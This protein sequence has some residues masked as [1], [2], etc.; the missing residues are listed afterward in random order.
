MKAFKFLKNKGSIVLAAFMLCSSIGTMFAHDTITMYD[1]KTGDT[2]SEDVVS[3]DGTLGN[4][5][6]VTGYRNKRIANGYA[7]EVEWG[8]MVF[9]Y[10]DGTYDPYTGEMVESSVIV[11]QPLR[12]EYGEPTGEVTMREFLY[13]EYYG[14]CYDPNRLDE[15]KIGYWYGS[16]RRNA[17][18]IIRNLSEEVVYTKI[19]PSKDYSNSS[20]DEINLHVYSRDSVDINSDKFTKMN[21]PEGSME[22]W[23]NFSFLAGEPNETRIIAS[24]EYLECYLKGMEYD[25]YGGSD[26]Y[27]AHARVNVFGTPGD[28]FKNVSDYMQDG[29][30]GEKI[31]EITIS[32]SK[33]IIK[34]GSYIKGD[35]LTPI[36]GDT[37]LTDS[38]DGSGYDYY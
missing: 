15:R 18:I 11:E 32:F 26:P 25:A 19:S 37:I 7:I 27:Y 33:A 8:N 6:T 21:G 12:D 35:D 17:D 36:N 34:D 13:H 30:V 14:P 5:K 29:N 24:D 9:I 22:Y 2:Y 4:T 20:L 3:G 1:N 31:G 23:D 28:D 16:N 38:D 10:D